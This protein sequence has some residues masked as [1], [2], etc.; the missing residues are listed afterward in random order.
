MLRFISI[1]NLGLKKIKNL[2][3][4]SNKIIHQ[5][6]TTIND[7]KEVYSLIIEEEERQKNGLELIASENFTSKAVMSCLGSV[8][9]NKYSEGLPGRR[10]YGGNE[11]IDKLENLCRNR[12][13]ECFRLNPEEWGVNVQPYSGS[14]ANLAAYG[15][16]LKPHDRIM[17]LDLPSGG[18]LTHGYY[19]K[20]KKISSTSIYYESLPYSIDNTG[21]ID[22]D[23]LEDKARVFMP[24]LIVCGGSAYPRDLDYERFRQ[25]ADIN[26]AYLMCDM[27]H[28]SGLV[29]TQECKNPFDYCDIVT[30]TTHKTLRGPRAGMIFFKKELEN[31]MNFSVFPGHQGG[32]HNNKIG[33]ISTQLKQVMSQEFKEDLQH[34]KRNAKVLATTLM[35]YGYTLST[36]GTDTHL[37][38]CNLNPLGLTGSKVETVCDH[39]GIT[40]NKNS[41]FGDTS[42]LSPG[43]IRIGT[44]ALTSRGFGEEE[45]IKVGNLIHKCIQLS[46]EIQS[47]CESKKLK[48]FKQMLKTEKY[49]DKIEVIHNE[50]IILASSFPLYN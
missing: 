37:I 23:A 27:A 1:N 46:L 36:N 25:I 34:V 7:D 41:V 17:G 38:L 48:E 8:L 31:D 44:P 28:F 5:M 35:H 15:G 50:V 2:R 24:K 9:T 42:A 32:P 18:H 11:V 26:N 10:Y 40:L 49:Q 47:D 6:N 33:G 4:I 22:Y 45:F 3:H 13:L 19:T 16:V 29:A 30:T 14:V 20:K 12:A 43:G 39:V 21:Y